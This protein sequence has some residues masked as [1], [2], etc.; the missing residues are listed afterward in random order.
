MVQFIGPG[1]H[2]QIGQILV[3]ELASALAESVGG[4]VQRASMVPGEIAWDE[5][6]CGLLAISVRRWWLSDDFPEG[7]FAQSIV[8]SSPCNLPW[9]IGEFRIQVIRCA[10][11]PQGNMLSV[12]PGELDTA[13][14]VLIAD[15]HVTINTT[16]SVLCDLKDTDQIIDYTIGET[17]T[18]GP[19]GGCVGS[20][21]IVFIAVYRD[22]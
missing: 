3:T 7:Q 20:E 13:A 9:M 14:E 16:T 8:R 18:Q 12:P 5:C 19:N 4:P 15:A 11:N 17:D 2:Y 21:L 22:N 1:A 10:P 6:D